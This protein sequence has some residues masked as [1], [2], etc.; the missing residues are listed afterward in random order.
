M[1][2]ELLVVSGDG[3]LGSI[4]HLWKCFILIEIFAHLS[5]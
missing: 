4:S 1:N 5:F 3:F 2:G